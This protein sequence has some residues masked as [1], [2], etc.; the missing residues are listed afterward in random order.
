M[1]LQRRIY[2]AN[3]SLQYFLENSWTF[4][5]NKVKKMNNSL[6]PA[7]TESFSCLDNIISPNEFLKNAAMGSRRYLLKESDDT[8]EQAKKHS[9]RMYWASWL[10]TVI[11]YFG[12]IWLIFFKI[13]VMSLFINK[14]RRV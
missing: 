9:N 8:I 5:N 7:D 6:H 13:E 2:T 10:F 1:R 12:L 11:W 4:I 14:D 3:M